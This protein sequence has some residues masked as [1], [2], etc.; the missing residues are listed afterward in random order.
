MDVEKILRDMGMEVISPAGTLKT[1]LELARTE[2]LD[3]AI[4]DVNLSDGDLSTP[5]AEV[6]STRGIPFA[7]ATGYSSWVPNQAFAT[8]VR[9]GKPFTP[10]QL[11][12]VVE[13]ILA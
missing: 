11:Q 3:C 5:V 8:A 12:K 7:F 10:A 9:L 2:P 4:L 6:L 13:T 1:A